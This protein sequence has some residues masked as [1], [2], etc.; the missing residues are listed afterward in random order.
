MLASAGGDGRLDASPRGGDPGFVK[1]VDR[2]TLL[3]GD[4]SGNNRLDTLTNVIETGRV[5]LLFLVPGV[6][7]TLRING[8]AQLSREP[9][10]LRWFDGERH[11]PIVVMIIAVES[12]YL[13]C[14]KALM[15]SRLWAV[16]SQISRSE[17]P[18][19]GQMINDQIGCEDPPESHEAMLARYRRQL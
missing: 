15:R 10:W 17:F 8:R 2:R 3:L 5:G 1:V 6:D 19:M 7:E 13:H 12:A 4:A 9:S 14:A 11:S 16:D 18:P